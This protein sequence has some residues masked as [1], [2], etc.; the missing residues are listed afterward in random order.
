MLTKI[1]GLFTWKSLITD[2]SA[3]VT[4]NFASYFGGSCSLG[5]VFCILYWLF[6][7]IWSMMETCCS[8]MSVRR[9]SHSVKVVLWDIAS[10]KASP[11]ACT[12]THRCEESI[13]KC[14]SGTSQ[15]PKSWIT[16]KNPLLA[17][18]AVWTSPHLLS[19]P[20][21]VPPVFCCFA[22]K[23]HFYFWE[24]QTKVRNIDGT[25]CCISAMWVI[26]DPPQCIPVIDTICSYTT[27]KIEHEKRGFGSN[28]HGK[29]TFTQLSIISC[30]PTHI[31]E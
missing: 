7:T 9:T 28:S 29:T 16:F 1:S 2:A 30:F 14:M 6:Q 31:Y 26:F 23:S 24:E 22:W 18:L 8:S 3:Y 21:L 20:S 12:N 13:K 17:T 15:H 19:C 10:A 5:L 11:P 27:K 4:Q 25:A